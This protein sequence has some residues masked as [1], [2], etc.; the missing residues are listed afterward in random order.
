[1]VQL[2]AL[3]PIIGGVPRL[4]SYGRVG[5]LLLPSTHPDRD[6]RSH[7]WTI[8]VEDRPSREFLSFPM[9]RYRAKR[10]EST[11]CQAQNPKQI[12]ITKI[13]NFKQNR[14]GHLEIGYWNLFY[15]NK[16]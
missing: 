2:Q 3:Q 14:L 12:P 7:S 10:H 11:K 16:G 6:R 4:P 5:Q 8:W 13:Q 1:M 9:S 15:S